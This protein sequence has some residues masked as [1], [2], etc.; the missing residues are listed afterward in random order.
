MSRHPFL[1]TLLAAMGCAREDGEACM[2]V[3]DDAT[4]CPAP[5]DVDDSVA[6]A[7]MASR[8]QHKPQERAGHGPPPGPSGPGRPGGFKRFPPKHAG[9]GSGPPRHRGPGGPR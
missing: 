4:S 3:A 2:V 5:E 1:L 6:L 7:A 8:Q 9:G